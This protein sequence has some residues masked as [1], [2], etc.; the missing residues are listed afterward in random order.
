[1]PRLGRFPSLSNKISNSLLIQLWIIYFS[2]CRTIIFNNSIE[3][4]KNSCK[5]KH[6]WENNS[7]L[8]NWCD[9]DLGLPTYRKIWHWKFMAFA[10]PILHQCSISAPLINFRIFLVFW[11]FQE[12]NKSNVGLKWV[13]KTSRL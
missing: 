2:K 10:E 7:V 5:S 4:N 1:M 8:H 12:V 6:L 11:R 3:L 13:E 9:S